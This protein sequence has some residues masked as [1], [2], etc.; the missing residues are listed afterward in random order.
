[1]KKLAKRFD[2][3]D[4]GWLEEHK[5]KRASGE[6]REDED[7]MDVMITILQDDPQ[8]FPGRD[9]DTVNKG[10]LSGY[11]LSSLRHYNGDIDMGSHIT[12]QPP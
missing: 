11:D 2:I 6:A 5:K 4:Q 3:L 7:F 10:H 12:S 8:L 9:A 1:M